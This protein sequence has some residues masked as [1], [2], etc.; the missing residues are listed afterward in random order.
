MRRYLGLILLAIITTAVL[1]ACGG[2]SSGPTEGNLEAR[3]EAFGDAVMD[4]NY[5]KLYEFAHPDSKSQCSKGEFL[6]GANA[7]L[8]SLA[9]SMGLDEDAEPKTVIRAML[10]LD[11]DADVEVRASAA[12]VIEEIEGYVLLKL[13][14][15]GVLIGDLGNSSWV[16]ADGQ[17]F[18]ENA[19]DLDECG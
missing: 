8:M 5:S 6:T 1:T 10:G 19:I 12:E 3:A 15:E 13:Y 17:W 14:Q 11:E 16:F 9:A 4:G 7:A 18:T 2:G